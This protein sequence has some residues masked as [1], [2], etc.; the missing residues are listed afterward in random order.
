MKRTYDKK[1]KF[2]SFVYNVVSHRINKVC[3]K[4][5]FADEI[6]YILNKIGY[7]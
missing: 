1:N 2:D 5:L 6:I 4:E 3:S 7:S